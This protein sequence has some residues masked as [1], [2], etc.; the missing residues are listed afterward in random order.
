MMM[1]GVTKANSKLFCGMDAYYTKNKKHKLVYS[2]K[3]I[4]SLVTLPFLQSGPISLYFGKT[5]YDRC[6]FKKRN[7]LDKVMQ[8]LKN[9]CN[10]LESA[11]PSF[12]FVHNNN[13]Q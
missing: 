13:C 9:E 6:N 8:V 11:I 2:V 3:I 10:N 1:M 7:Y 12:P 5:S 4:L